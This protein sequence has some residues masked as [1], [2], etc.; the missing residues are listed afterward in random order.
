QVVERLCGI[1]DLAVEELLDTARVT[2][3]R[4]GDADALRGFE[5]EIVTGGAVDER[6]DVERRRE[7]APADVLDDEPRRETFP[8]VRNCAVPAPELHQQAGVFR[9]A[10]VAVIDVTPETADDV[11]GR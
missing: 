1:E 7:P 5:P 11:G 6:L 9:C 4:I 2:R 3:R 8:R 10:P